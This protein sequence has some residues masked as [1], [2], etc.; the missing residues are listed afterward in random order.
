MGGRSVGHG[1]DGS[2]L[3]SRGSPRRRR[4]LFDLIEGLDQ[5]SFS[6]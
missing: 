1:G 5:V 3:G 4:S 6:L 2:G